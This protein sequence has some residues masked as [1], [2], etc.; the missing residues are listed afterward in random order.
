ML[1]LT[2]QNFEK[3]IESAEKPVLVDFWIFW[4]VPCFIIAPILEK[5][6]KEYEGKIILAKANLDTVPI[7]GQKYGVDKIPTVILFNKGKPVS[8]LVGAKPEPEIREW[9]ESS[10]ADNDD[11]DDRV[12]ELIKE[13]EEYAKQ[14]GFKLNPDKTILE[15]LIKRLLENERKYRARYCPCRR[16][17]GNSKDDEEIVCPCKSCPEEVEKNGYC[18]CRL[19]V[20]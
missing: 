10:L 3:E 7:A 14:N 5:L 9:L 2:D 13:Y 17:S 8:A 15:M 16:L 4:C 6:A 12:E 18:H 19:F 20:K 1:T 11:D